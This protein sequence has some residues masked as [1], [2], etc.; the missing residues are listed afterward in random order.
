MPTRLSSSLEVVELSLAVLSIAAPSLAT[1]L[2]SVELHDSTL[3]KPFSPS[4][5]GGGLFKYP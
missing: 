2:G 3:L 4:S 5:F 1:Q